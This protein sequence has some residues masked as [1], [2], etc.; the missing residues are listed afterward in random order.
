[1]SNN[2]ITRRNWLKRIGLVAGTAILSPSVPSLFGSI[3]KNKTILVHSSWQTLN[4]GDIAHTPGLIKILEDYSPD[5]TVILWPRSELDRGVE[6][7]MRKGFPSLTIVNGEVDEHGK[8]SSLEL[9]EAF[10]KADLMIHGS[11]ASVVG[12]KGLTCWKEVT[13][14]PYGIYGVTIP[15][16]DSEIEDLLNGATF[17]FTRET[18]SL[19]NLAEKGISG[20]HTGF[21]PDA[22]FAMHLL[23]S[24]K[25]SEFMK[26]HALESRKFICVI[27]RLRKTPSYRTRPNNGGW[28]EQR[29]NAVD[30]LNDK[31]KEK[32]HAKAREAMITYV[33]KTG[34]KVLVCPE[35]TYQLDIMD[36]LLIDPLPDDVKKNVIKRD[37]YWLPDEAS[38]VYKEALAV[39]SFE[40][41]SPIMAFVN[42]TPAFYLRQP[43]DTI[44]GQMW[45]DIGVED[46][47]F[48]IEET[49]GEDIAKQLMKV[50][51]DFK[52][53]QLY[54]QKA[55]EYVKERHRET[56][57]FVNKN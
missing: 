48:E 38:S 44:K 41:H 56:F 25:A 12:K 19:N 16:I 9:K 52:A 2:T 50:Q 31:H 26:T 47:V 15:V 23:N 40:C 37:T 24:K 33:R 43:E 18:H 51:E 39:I 34:N 36:E 5:T 27:P 30:T 35:M 45:Y 46:W 54:Q 20:V 32:D 28:S 49:Q 1:M 22:T 3:L 55:M 6:D 21:A 4:I 57:Q 42:G 11:G 29:I 53:A 10:K 14:K 7:M 17:I 8:P 13:G